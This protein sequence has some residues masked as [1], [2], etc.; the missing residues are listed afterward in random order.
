MASGLV[1]VSP[2]TR[3]GR[4]V[5]AIAVYLG[6]ASFETR[7]LGTFANADRTAIGNL[8]YAEIG[9]AVTGAGDTNA[10][11]YADVLAWGQGHF[12]LFGGSAT[13]PGLTPMW[14]ID[15]PPP[16]PSISFY[17]SVSAGDVN[18]DGIPDLVLG[19]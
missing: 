17:D 9:W 19:C 2:F 7:P 12:R 13:G 6:Q 4:R 10:D 3:T 5:G 14:A 1:V 11:G 8:P 16:S 15:L 18:G